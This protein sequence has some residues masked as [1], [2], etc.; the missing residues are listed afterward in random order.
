MF[1][2]SSMLLQYFRSFVGYARVKVFIALGLAVT[3]GLLQGIGLMMLI[4]F[5]QLIGLGD[6]SVSSSGVVAFIGKWLRIL[7]LPL[8]LAVMLGCYVAI[9]AGHALLSRYQTILSAEIVQGYTQALRDRLYEAL[10]YVQWLRFIRVPSAEITHVLTSDLQMVALAT[11]QFLQLVGAIILTAVYLGVSSVVSIPLTILALCC[12]VGLL[13]VLGF[14]NRMSNRSGELL[15][16]TMNQLHSAVSEHLGGMKLVRSYGSEGRHLEDFSSATRGIADQFVSFSRIT[17]TSA[18]F[19]QIGAALVLSGFLYGAVEVAHMEPA[20]LLLLVF[21]YSRVLPRFSM[22]QQNVQRIVHALPSF[23]AA[24]HMQKSFEAEAERIPTILTPR[25]A[26][27]KGVRFRKVS[28]R[29][30]KE[31]QL[32]ALK[33]IDFEVPARTMTAIVGPSGSGKSTLADLLIG[34][35]LPESGEILVDGFPLTDGRLWGWRQ[36]MGYVPQET[37]LFHETIRTNLLWAQPAASEDDLWRA[38]RAAAAEEFV[39]SL[40]EGLETVVGDRGINLSGGERQRI[41]LARALLRRPSLLLLDEATS[42]MDMANEKKIQG[43]IEQMSGAMTIVVI[44]HRL[45]TVRAADRIIV[46]D[47]GHVIESGTW[48]ELRSNACSFL[49]SAAGEL[50]TSNDS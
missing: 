13:L 30:Q 29:Y 39:A 19:Y 8:N 22:I 32:F 46:L 47:R 42:N 40:S 11:Q 36:S 12:A 24:T 48:N 25:V 17:S 33:D 21:I 2:N 14:Y 18:M 9:V 43:A 10:S 16:E 27:R 44:A 5:M 49:L 41:A 23:E 4:P 38:L 26:L 45:S 20:R 35:L 34:L 37:F 7:G 50:K 31:S 1:L 3:L 28:F 15:R 6:S